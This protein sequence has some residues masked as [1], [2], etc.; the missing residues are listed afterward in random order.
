LAPLTVH[1]GDLYTG[2][3][4]ASTLELGQWL[5]QWLG[6]SWWSLDSPRSVLSVYSAFSLLSAGSLLSILSINS[7][8]SVLSIGSAGSVLSIGCAGSILSIGSAGSVCSIGA[9]GAR[10]G[11]IEAR[12]LGEER[13]AESRRRA[14]RVLPHAS[15]AAQSAASGTFSWSAMRCAVVGRNGC[16]ASPTIR[17]LSTSVYSVVSSRLVSAAPA[18]SALAVTQG[19]VSSTYRL[20]LREMLKSSNPRATKL[21]ASLR[22]DSGM[23]PRRPESNGSVSEQPRVIA[24]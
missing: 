21:R 22:R 18:R 6:V 11:G 12:A 24:Q 9:R 8:G 2:W 13:P 23:M 5:G 7:V 1:G 15:P 17:T 10:F 20:A 3:V 4:S 14:G 16:S 19:A